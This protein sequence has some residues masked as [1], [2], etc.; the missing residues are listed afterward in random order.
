MVLISWP[1]SALSSLSQEG[2]M[3]VLCMLL[4]CIDLFALHLYL[5]FYCAREYIQPSF[6]MSK[7]RTFFYLL[8]FL[9]VFL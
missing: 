3:I 2:G 4:L 7:I 8:S 5:F 6:S 1:S 9:S